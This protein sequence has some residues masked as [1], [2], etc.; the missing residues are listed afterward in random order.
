MLSQVLTLVDDFARVRDIF[1]EQNL[2]IDEEQSGLTYVPL[3]T[4]QVGPAGCAYTI[5]YIR[6]P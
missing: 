6:N 2:P 1:R 4:V 3:S 5:L